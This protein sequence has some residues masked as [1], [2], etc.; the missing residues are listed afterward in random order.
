MCVA[1]VL[2]N[3]SFHYM[4]K[5]PVMI[6]WLSL[7]SFLFMDTLNNFAI[8]LIRVIESVSRFHI[9]LVSLLYLFVMWVFQSLNSSLLLNIVFWTVL[10][11]VWIYLTCG[12]IG[13]PI[14]KHRAEETL[15]W[16]AAQK[17]HQTLKPGGCRGP[18]FTVH[19][20]THSVGCCTNLAV[21]RQQ[22]HWFLPSDL[23]YCFIIT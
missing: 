10:I 5:C 12:C 13:E 17:R 20:H 1:V 4:L 15:S 14:Q 6:I 16:T 11:V 21:A 3:F 19:T 8:I 7:L 9:L 22:Q 23:L 2:F 18:P